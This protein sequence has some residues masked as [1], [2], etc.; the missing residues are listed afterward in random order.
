M[1]S[2]DS[3]SKRD[4]SVFRDEDDN[5]IGAGGWLVALRPSAGI[6]LLLV[7]KE[8]PFRRHLLEALEGRGHAAIAVEGGTEAIAAGARQRFAV[9]LLLIGPQG[10]PA[11]M[12]RLR[13]L[14]PDLEVV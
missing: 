6:K 11:L 2:T 5:L 14:D 4:L 13:E 3:K 10:A 12:A 7:A 9:A 8:G 1:R